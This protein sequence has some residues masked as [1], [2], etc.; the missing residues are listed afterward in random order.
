MTNLRPGA[1]KKLELDYEH[2]KNKYP[3]LVYA[4]IT[5]FGEKGPDA[6]QPG[7]DVV[8]Y[9]ARSGFMVDL[10]KPDEYPMYAPAGF[11]DLTVGGLLFGGVCAALLNRERTGRG[12]KI[13]ISLYGSVIWF[14]GIVMTTTQERYGNTYPKTRLEGNP[15]AIPY[16]CRDGE[17]IMLSILEVERYWPVLCKTLGREDL[18]TDE[19]FKN[20]Q[21]IQE[22]RSQLI[23]ILEE[24][25]LSKDAEEWRTFLKK[26]DIAHEKLCH[27]KDIPKDPQ[28]WRMT[29]FTKERLKTVK[30][31]SCPIRPS[32]PRK[33]VP[34]R[35]T[36]G[37]YWGS[38][39]WKSWRNWAILPG[40]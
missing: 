36:A 10:V 20:R 5:G 35:V 25:F 29:I 33:S 34:S 39:P 28:A 21:A 15:L 22:H 38:I 9:W 3:R 24:I 31:P 18:I 12:D 1:L 30:R 40:R 6:G 23:P 13:S 4:L 32:A 37:R 7:F 14:A 17:W 27:F 8:A 26:A 11:G 19:R 16:K 2:L